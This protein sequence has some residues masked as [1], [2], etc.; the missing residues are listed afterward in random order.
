LEYIDIFIE[1]LSK[2][3]LVY[4]SLR[5]HSVLNTILSLCLSVF[6]LE[7][8]NSFRIIGVKIMFC[9]I[10]MHSLWSFRFFSRIEIHSTYFALPKTP[11]FN[12]RHF[13][14][15]RSKRSLETSWLVVMNSSCDSTL[16]GHIKIYIRWVILVLMRSLWG[17]NLMVL[18]N[19]W[20]LCPCHS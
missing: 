1:S 16:V 10:I 3:S 20:L 17:S 12:W 11:M 4:P 14:N 5:L 19:L 8:T 9:L 15:C 18:P 2:L 13:M 6:Y 7:C